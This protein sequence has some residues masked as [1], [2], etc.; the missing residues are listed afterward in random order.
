MIVLKNINKQLMKNNQNKLIQK[1]K[2]LVQS[3]KVARKK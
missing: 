3:K 1:A 2:S